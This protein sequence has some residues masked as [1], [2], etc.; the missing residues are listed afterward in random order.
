[1]K[2]ILTAAI[3]L[4]VTGCTTIVAPPE[5]F[6]RVPLPDPAPLQKVTA[7]KA[8]DGY[9]LDEENFKKEIRNVQELKAEIPEV[10]AFWGTGDL[11][12][13][14]AAL[15]EFSGDMSYSSPPGMI[16]DRDS[17][18]ILTTPPAHGLCE[19]LRGV[20]ENMLFLHHPPAQRYYEKP[21]GRLDS[22]RSPNARRS[23]SPRA[24]FN[25]PRHDELWT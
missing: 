5:D 2:T 18:R 23:R 10:D 21:G 9:H 13:L 15:E 20:L 14:P 6:P 1:M 8:V 4:L 12:R 3:L 16:Y 11:F 25:R 24:Q 19:G 7:T 22:R 17:P